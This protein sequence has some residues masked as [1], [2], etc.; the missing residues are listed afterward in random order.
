MLVFKI[1]KNAEDEWN[2]NHSTLSLQVLSFK[3]VPTDVV[4]CVKIFFK[5]GLTP[6]L[7]YQEYL[8]HLRRRSKNELDLHHILA[9]RSKAP[10]KRDFNSF[11]VEYN[12]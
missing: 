7:A 2:H 10:R 1:L 11:Y 4:E 6:G 3:D 5:N 12:R 9:N 8:K